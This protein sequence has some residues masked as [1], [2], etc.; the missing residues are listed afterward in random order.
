MD[1]PSINVR[2]RLWEVARV[3]LL[4]GSTS[5]GGPAAHVAMM[6]AEVVRRRGWVTRRQFLDLYSATNFIPG[7]NSTEMAIHLGYARAGWPGL[8][9]AGACFIMPA[10][11]I[12]TACAAVYVRYGE[13]PQIGSIFRAVAP[14]IV[15]I[16]AHAIWNLGR[17]SAS[18]KPPSLIAIAVGAGVAASLGVNEIVVLAVAGVLAAAT[19]RSRDGETPGPVRPAVSAVPP[20]FAIPLGP[21]LPAS[22]GASV[23]CTPGAIF[24]VFAKIGSVLFGSGY[25]LLAFLEAELVERRGWLSPQQMIDA[26]S[27]GQFTP[28]PVFTTATFIGYLLHGLSG[29]GAATAGIF[30]PAFVFVALS[31][32]VLPWLRR[33]RA[34]GAALDG[35]N[36]ASVALM[37]VVLV[38]LARHSLTSWVPIAIFLASLTA[39][40]RWKF[41]SAWLVLG[42]ALI[43][44]VQWWFP[45]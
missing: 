26:V 7:P 22:L 42:A 11:A 31:V 5:F 39:L 4:L 41:N 24:W 38:S 33:S 19:S 14:V 43:G 44:M 1:D 8:V 27:V 9:V 18:G 15:A 3:F 2:Q 16:V 45:R 37:A 30:L 29:A 28:G 34:V 10:V 40:T 23:A 12:V 35:V 17:A 20:P 36:A 13:L 32:P 6:E 25:V 21:L